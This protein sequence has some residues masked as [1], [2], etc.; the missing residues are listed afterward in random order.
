MYEQRG[1]ER[2]VMSNVINIFT[3]KP[4]NEKVKLPRVYSIKIEQMNPEED[5]GRQIIYTPSNKKMSMTVDGKTLMFSDLMAIVMDMC[6]DDPMLIAGV[7]E[8]LELYFEQMNDD[9]GIEDDGE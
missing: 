9:D 5:D 4:I 7:Y 3:K 6:Y 2:S 8:S 1:V